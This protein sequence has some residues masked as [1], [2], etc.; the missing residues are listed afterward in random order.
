MNDV[1]IS[2]SRRDKVFTQKLYETLTAAKLTVWADWDSIPAASD[3]DAEIKQGIQETNSVLFLLSPEWIK[4]N[5]C[6]KEMIH[7]VQMGKRLFPILYL[8][9][10][11][12]DVPPELAKINWIY[13]R[14]TDDFDQAFQTLRAA[15]DT[16]LDWIKSHTR[17]QNRAIEWDKKNRDNS[18]ALR[19]KDLADGEQFMVDASGKSPEV[20]HLQGEYVLSS[21]KVAERQRRIVTGISIAGLIIMAILAVFGF[22]QANVATKQ[23]KISRAGELSAQAELSIKRGFHNSLLLAIESFHLLDSPQTRGAV[24]DTAAANPQLLQFLNGNKSPVWSVAF[25]PD[26]KTL[27]S[28]TDDNTIVLWGVSTGLNAG[29]VTYTPIGQPLTGHTYPVSSVAFSPDGKTLASG[30]YDTT[31]ILWDV[32]TGKPI[33]QP[34]TG[35]TNSISSVAFSPDGKTLA[36]GSAD[37]TIILWDVSTGKPIGQPLTGHT[38]DINSVAFN[39]DGKMLA[40]GSDDN[41]IILW[42]VSSGAPIGQPFTGHT[43]VIY[44]VAFSPDGKTLASGSEDATIILWDVSTGKP[45]GQPLTGH[46]D[47]VYSV[48]FNP[49]GKT[50]VSGSDDTTIILWDVSLGKPIGQPLTGHT[51]AVVSVAFSPD[52]KTLAS[53]SKDNTIILW[54]ISTGLNASVSKYVPIGQPLTGHTSSVYSVAFSPDGK[55]LASGSDDTTIILWDVATGKPIGQPL[56]GHKGPVW[57][58]VFSPDGKTLA[59]GSDDNTIILWDVSSGKSISQP[60]TGHTSSVYSVAFSPDGKTL[61]SGSYDATIILWDVAT[62]KPI[63]QPLIGHTN[64]LLSVAFSPDGKTLAS[65]SYDTT[66]ILWDVLS[67]KPIGEPLAEHISY[68]NSVA[69]SP[70]GKTLASG[71]YDST[72]IFWDVSMRKSIGQPLTGH[73]NY[74]WSVA[75]SPDGKTLTSGSEDNTIILW[76]IDMQS[77]IT[78]SCQRAGRNFTRAEWEKY[79]FT[80]P[81]RKTCEQWP[82]EGE[83]TPTLTTTP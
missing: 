37:D 3:W 10:D 24:L 13:M 5:E 18:F 21:R 16:D 80:E 68:V 79:N 1:F 33:G 77:W 25:S 81:Y 46:T 83:A 42:D 71:S 30:S 67:H 43:D 26:G 38:S 64:G 78:Q 27:A 28:G 6:R 44:T 9:V 8:P 69:F 4:S 15:M 29:V 73:T 17:I 75:F 54:N 58:V 48:A 51:N 56:T 20:T 57:S 70:D 59:S 62:G 63:G 72:I 52:S 53:G 7:A 39:P 40:S 19:G 35:H 41:T 36:S 32:S 66:I 45:I 50:L 61:A 34:L 49:D 12:N 22:Y 65:G 2:Y 11:P 55:M 60:L 47:V 23:A 76:D 31:I 14:E 74:V 82:L